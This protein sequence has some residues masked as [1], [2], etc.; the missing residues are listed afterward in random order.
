MD[1][2][3]NVEREM[4]VTSCPSLYK[5]F[6]WRVGVGHSKLTM[7]FVVCT[8]FDCIFDSTL[9]FSCRWCCGYIQNRALGFL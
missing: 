6:G 8:S 4:V 3:M 1:I 2:Y 9:S 5:V 7:Q